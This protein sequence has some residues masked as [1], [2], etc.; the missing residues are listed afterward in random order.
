M[1]RKSD[2][3]KIKCFPKSCFD[4]VT[5]TFF[6]TS[7][8]KSPWAKIYWVE[9]CFTDTLKADYWKSNTLFYSTTLSILFYLFSIYTCV[10]LMDVFNG[11]SLVQLKK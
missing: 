7:A 9:N 10:L 5:A 11:C 3:K 4:I 1:R 8:E 6:V 2:L